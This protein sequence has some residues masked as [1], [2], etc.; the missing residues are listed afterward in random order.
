VHAVDAVLDRLHQAAQPRHILEAVLDRVAPH[1][2]Q[3]RVEREAD[4]QRHQHGHRDGDAE[5]QEEAADDAV[6][7]GDRHEHG[8]D[9]E[10]GGHH[11]QADFVGAVVG[12]LQVA[13]AHAEVAHDVFAHHDRVVDQQADAQRQRHQGQEI[14]REA[15]ELHRDEAGHHRDRQ[16]QAGDDGAAPRVQEQEHDQHGQ[17]R[18]FDDGA[19]DVVELALHARRLV[20]QDASS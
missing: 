11:R 15:E 2:R 6:H 7:E 14:E 16:R 19:L 12:G 1:R 8:D 9:G 10:G 13:L 17:Q 3:H 20:F 4:E 18:A 5:L